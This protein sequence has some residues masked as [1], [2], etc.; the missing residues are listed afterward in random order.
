M[1][2]LVT[3]SSTKIPVRKMRAAAVKRLERIYSP[4]GNLRDDILFIVKI[5]RQK[6][7]RPFI[8]EDFYTL[9]EYARHTKDSHLQQA[10]RVGIV[11]GMAHASTLDEMMHYYAAQLMLEGGIERNDALEEARHYYVEAGAGED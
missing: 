9:I 11:E 6:D 1:A 2:P 3:L 5:A 7:V 8:F 10:I 4:N